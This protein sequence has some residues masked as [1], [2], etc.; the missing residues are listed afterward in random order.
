M[1]DDPHISRTVAR[2][3]AVIRLT[4]PR[5]EI[6]HVMGPGLGESNPNP[7]TWRTELNRPLIGDGRRRDAVNG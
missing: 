6:Q 5:A 1:L 7:A 3:I 4:V 2:R